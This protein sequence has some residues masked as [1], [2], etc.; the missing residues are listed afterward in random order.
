M[1]IWLFVWDWL[2]QVQC[3][4][5]QAILIVT[6]A[7]VALTCNLKRHHLL[8]EKGAKLNGIAFCL[9]FDISQSVK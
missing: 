5:M 2:P 8:E 6:I 9:N 1:K 3:L 4:V 7:V